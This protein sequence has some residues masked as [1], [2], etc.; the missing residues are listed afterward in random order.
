ML[1]QV[2]KVLHK[3]KSDFQEVEVVQTTPFGRLL[4]TDGLMQSSQVRAV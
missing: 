1:H 3:G 4:I 2:E